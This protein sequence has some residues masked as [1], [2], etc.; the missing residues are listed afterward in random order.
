MAEDDDLDD[1]EEKLLPVLWRYTG[2]WRYTR[3][4]ATPYQIHHPLL[5]EPF[6]H[7]F[8][9]SAR[10]NRLYEVKSAWVREAERTGDWSE[11]VFFHAR[12]YRLAALKRIASKL[13]DKDYW[14]LVAEVWQN[15]ENIH[16]NR[17]EWIRLWNAERPGKHQYAMDAKGRKALA[18][19]PDVLTIYRGIK[20][21]GR[22]GLSWTLDR[23]KA[24]WF[25]RRFGGET[26]LTA[27]AK[28]ADA[29]A[30]FLDI[31]KEVV[32]DKF[33]IRAIEKVGRREGFG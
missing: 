18:R 14:R 31:E 16:Q 28:K 19:Q 8:N 10:V 33:E 13:T 6:P 9:R 25:A 1:R 7:D 21:K 22:N 5:I 2:L 29:H 27:R 23:E 12:P 26:L 20:G 17:T 30:T 24:I 4:E 15:S 11:Y 3:D 32:I